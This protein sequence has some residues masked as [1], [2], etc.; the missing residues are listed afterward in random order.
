[1]RKPVDEADIQ[2]FLARGGTIK[3][4]PTVPPDSEKETRPRRKKPAPPPVGEQVTTIE[5]IFGKPSSRRER[6]GPTVESVF[7]D[8]KGDS[9]Y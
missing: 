4:I 9:G 6:T 3:K 8:K 2:A 7:G 5:S 1:M